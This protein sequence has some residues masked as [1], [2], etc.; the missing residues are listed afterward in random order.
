MSMVIKDM[1][2]SKIDVALQS[3]LEQRTFYP[4]YPGNPMT[5]I[6][7]ENFKSM[8]FPEGNLPDILITP[9]DLMLYAKVTTLSSSF[10]HPALF[11]VLAY[12]RCYLCEPRHAGEGIGCW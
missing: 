1:K 9:S 11:S 5:P 12:R 6:D 7:W 2:L 8:M 4:L 3:V 10:S